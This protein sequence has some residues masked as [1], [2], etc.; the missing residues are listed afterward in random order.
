MTGII[1]SLQRVHKKI[2]LQ[3]DER[4]MQ[5]KKNNWNDWMYPETL[6]GI[7]ESKKAKDH[8]YYDY[9]NIVIASYPA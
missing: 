5:F 3:A 9:G 7:T 6:P 1:T 4:L 2:K 8:W